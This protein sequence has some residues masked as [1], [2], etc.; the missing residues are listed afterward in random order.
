M[1]SLLQVVNMAPDSNTPH[2]PLVTGVAL[3]WYVGSITST[4]TCVVTDAD[5]MA[6]VSI[7]STAKGLQWVYA[8]ADY[9][10]NPQDGVKEKPLEWFELR[11]DVAL[12]V[13]AAGAEDNVEIFANGVLGSASGYRWTNPILP[14]TGETI[15]PLTIAAPPAG[16]APTTVAATV[17]AGVVT[18]F[19]GL[20]AGVGYTSADV[21]AAVTALLPSGTGA[22]ATATVG[23][24]DA[25]DNAVTAITVTIGGTGYTVAPTVVIGAPDIAGGTQAT[26]TANVSAGSVVSVTI[27]NPGSGYTAPP[28]ISFTANA[29][30]G[31]AVVGNIATVVGGQ[32]TAI[33]PVATVFT[34]S[35]RKLPGDRPGAGSRSRRR[36]RLRR[37]NGVITSATVLTP[38]AGYIAASR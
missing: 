36:V 8:V 15:V 33:T 34:C 18:G 35:R 20:P 6:S 2:Q 21:G 10:E 16:T 24:V 30:P 4:P 25:T 38:G 14:F 28:A 31:G 23:V 26:A 5:G 32:I 29:A 9:D 37:S 3:P 22:A 13:W 17:A 11:W 7:N 12:K 19:T 27:D 1:T